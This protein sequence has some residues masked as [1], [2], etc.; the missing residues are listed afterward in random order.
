MRLE[1]SGRYDHDYV[2]LQRALSRKLNLAIYQ[3]EQCVIFTHAD[4][5]ACMQLGTTLANDDAASVD[6]LATVDLDAKSFR[7]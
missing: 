5:F 2:T 6:G 3:R 7:L 1:L 4:V